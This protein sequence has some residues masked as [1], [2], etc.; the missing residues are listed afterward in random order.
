MINNQELLHSLK[1]VKLVLGNGFD[2]H[3]KLHS[4]YKHYFQ[5]YKRKY[6]RL[7]SV[8]SSIL[9]IIEDGILF[10]DNFVIDQ[11]VTENC[12]I[13]DYFFATLNAHY[14]E[15][16]DFS[17]CD[18]ENQIALSLNDNT[19][20]ISWPVVYE[21]VVSNKNK[22]NNYDN[23]MAAVF[24][25]FADCQKKNKKEDFYDFLLAQLKLFEEEFGNFI[26][27]QHF[28]IFRNYLLRGLQNEKYLLCVKQSLTDLC[29]VD[30]ISSIDT[31]NY[32]FIEEEPY[33]SKTSFIN[34]YI[35]CPIFGIDSI[36]SPD[37]PRFIF[38]KTSRR[39]MYDM[40][41]GKYSEPPMF[42]NII[43]YGHSLNKPDYSYFFPVLD[44]IEIS[45]HQA[46]SIFIYAY[47]IYDK[48]NKDKIEK[49]A[50][51]KV[52]SLFNDYAKSR[53]IKENLLDSLTTERRVVLC[54]IPELTS[55]KYNYRSHFDDDEYEDDKK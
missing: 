27:N 17:W 45:N 11:V 49:D 19:S 43:V 21:I 38:T 14:K 55:L 32:E 26:Y 8:I 4:S 22:D 9:K 51:L 31:F 5:K 29:N 34:G 7:T 33:F 40:E 23:L 53:G 48:N 3:C 10:L 25:K 15:C 12:N 42:E 18:V 13:W 6:D 44:K 30:E 54:E 35:D 20:P 2:L 39:L 46:K 36:H 16:N 28:N 37:D 41:H 24:L 52:S 1:N 47:S 50:C